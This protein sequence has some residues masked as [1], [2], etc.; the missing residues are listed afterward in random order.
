M[1]SPYDSLLNER[2]SIKKGSLIDKAVYL[3]EKSTIDSSEFILTDTNIHKRY[4]QEL[5]HVEPHKILEIPVGA[6]EDLFHT[7][8][9]TGSE[10]PVEFEILFYGTFLPLHGIDVIL[11]A[12]SMLRDHPLHFTLIG[13]KKSNRYYQMVRQAALNNVTH[14]EW[15]KFEDLP[16]LVARADLGLGGPFGNTGQAHRVITGK[17]FQ[18]LAMAKPVIVGQIEDDYGFEDKVNCLLIPQG[19]AE[20]LAK[21]ILWAYQ[22]RSELSQIGQRGYDLYQSRYSVKHISD[23]LKGVFAGEILSS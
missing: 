17:T 1:M 5:F 18:F 7:Y 3:Y 11:G 8:E 4:F 22:H 15:I 13:G 21:A 9:I 10:K 2:K 23:T 12:A 19:N 14:V 20:A 16:R 6:D